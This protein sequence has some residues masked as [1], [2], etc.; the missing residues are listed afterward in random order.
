MSS[1]GF[2]GGGRVTRILLMGWQHAG[3]MPGR[4]VVSDP[5]MESLKALQSR[6]PGIAAV[7]NANKD[8]ATQDIV[9]LAVHPPTAVGVLAEIAPVL[10]PHTIVVS[11]MPK[12]SITQLASML[13]GHDRIV[14]IIPNAASIVGRGYN[15]ITFSPS[16]SKQDRGRVLAL[17]ISHG[18]CPEVS[19]EHLEAYAVLT[20]MGPTY[21]WF[22]LY[23]LE[24]LGRSFGLSPVMAA[25]GIQAMAEGAVAVMASSGLS[26]ADVMDL[27][28]VRPL[29]DDEPVIRECYE[30]RLRGMY[31]KLKG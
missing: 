2:V 27:V 1:I 6:F 31:A 24:A 8:A 9:F 17:F 22:Q 23:E 29:G 26:P 4:V 28:P 11:L 14:R 10:Q 25:E 20:A 19:E 12:L 18:A 30:K 5:N 15:P 16:L 13:G 21:L 3:S 7:P